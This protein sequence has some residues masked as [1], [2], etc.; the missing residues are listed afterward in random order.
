M[1]KCGTLSKKQTEQVNERV[2]Q[3]E[4]AKVVTKR[5]VTHGAYTD[6]TPEYRKNIGRYAAEN[7]PAM[8]TRHF[9]LPETTGRKLKSE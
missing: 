4:E 1:F 8:S 6:Y 7:D 2:R 3:T 9:K 5:S